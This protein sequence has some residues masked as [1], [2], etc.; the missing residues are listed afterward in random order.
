MIPSSYGA[1]ARWQS[2]AGAGPVVRGRRASGDGDTIHFLSGNGFAGGVYW[3]FLRLFLPRHA[4]VTHDIEGH[5]DS[6]AAENY[7]GTGAV[8]ARIPQVMADLQLPATPL[9]GMGH[10]YGGA[11]TLAVA[12]R[13]PGLFRALV[14]L[15]PILLP[16]PAYWSMRMAA[17]LH[18]HPM[19]E[20]A[21]RRR[22]RWASRVEAFERLRGRGIYAG[23]S[24]EAL[25]CFIDYATRDAADGTRVLCC[26]KG[27]EAQ[28]FE[29][30][31]YPW[32]LLP[33]IEVP[34]LFLR[35]AQ[36]YGFFAWAERLAQRANPRVR[37]QQIAGGHCFM[38]QDASA[39]HA[40][41][42][43]FLDSL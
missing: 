19:A 20:S 1:L 14:L 16:W 7:S 23:W 35:G 3:P 38:Q 34:V 39:A 13:N 8:I 4:L 15:D 43:E 28:I 40:A 18:R 25:N 5:G 41:V 24:D 36:S 12:A 11:L 26:P 17:L 21:R 33:K 29:Q 31:V 22:D 10:S 9:I 6:D 37:V 2:S 42:Q 32:R 27:I 30:P